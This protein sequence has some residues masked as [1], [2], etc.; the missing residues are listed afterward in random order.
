MTAK[1]FNTN[2][3]QLTRKLKSEDS[4]YASIIRFVQI[5]YWIFIPMFT[6][7]TI[8]EYID[9]KSIM[10]IYSGVC[11]IFSF[12]FIAILFRSYYKDFKYVDY[13]L[14][15]L[16]M[17][18]KAANRYQL[19]PLRSVYFLMA[20]ALMDVGLTLDWL[21]ENT[22]LLHTQIIFVGGIVWGFI[23]GLII[24]YIRYKPLRDNALQLIKE[25]EE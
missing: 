5:M 14:P 7:K 2:L 16:Q 22:T 13:S 1:D 17:L 23:I 11:L 12:V 3:E 20:F 10:V 6:I 19:F 18:K 25:I 4:H 8:S 15:T 9:S 24:W 21:D